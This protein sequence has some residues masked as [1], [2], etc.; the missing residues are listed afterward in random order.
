MKHRKNSTH[1]LPLSLPLLG[2]LGCDPQAGEE[3]TGE[4]LLS[5]EGTIHRSTGAE[6][7][8]VPALL[9]T[10]FVGNVDDFLAG[11][12]YRAGLVRGTLEEAYPSQFRLT[13][14]EHPPE[15]L[16]IEGFNTAQLVLV[17]PDHPDSWVVP[18]TVQ[19]LSDCHESP[20]GR[21]CNLAET[22]CTAEGECFEQTLEC[23]AKPCEVLTSG[24]PPPGFSGPP[25]LDRGDSAKLGT[26][27]SLR[28]AEFE[29]DDSS[30]S[31]MHCT[32]GG[33]VQTYETCAPSGACYSEYRAC[34]V[35]PPEV[36]MVARGIWGELPCRVLEQSGS[37]K[38]A[39]LVEPRLASMNVQVMYT[40]E[41]ALESEDFGL[42]VVYPG[43]EPG[44]NLIQAPATSDMDAP[45]LAANLQCL[46]A[47]ESGASLRGESGSSQPL[48][49]AQFA[50]LLAEAE[51]RCGELDWLLPRVVNGST[52]PPI[53]LSFS[54][55][56]GDFPGQ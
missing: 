17:S 19:E 43:L 44:Y 12:Y 26:A 25:L 46:Q 37:S 34:A 53:E 27:L 39:R 48:T 24:E 29:P 8:L 13:F 47:L 3:R 50:E 36:G 31:F 52:P 21:V 40:N 30:E 41:E 18:R 4:A 10:N 5:L 32:R 55:S 14:T 1:F 9:F 51:E 23:T 42:D 22:T 2:A 56:A 15:E 45:T 35:E 7:G 11:R 6:T 54:A 38:V 20:E 16:L 28:F 49:G 33:C